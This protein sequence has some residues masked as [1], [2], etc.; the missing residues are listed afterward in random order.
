VFGNGHVG[1]ALVQVLSAVPVE[2]RWIDSREH[3]FP[4]D[5]AGNVEIVATD[6]PE[7]EIATAPRGACIVVMTHSH[8]LDFD[9]IEAALA[10][11][12]WRY[13]GLIGSRAKRVQFERRLA[14]RGVAPEVLARVTC[15]IGSG[16]LRGKEPGVIAVAVAAE[17]LAIR[18]ASQNDA[19]RLS[20]R[21]ANPPST[22]TRD[23]R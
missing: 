21:V 19:G 9:I 20:H 5:V 4:P 6:A 23:G 10:R 8:A 7:T 18:E 14:A 15:P 2:V 16:Q 12:D 13:L 3:D 1:R 11:S 17:L 22:R